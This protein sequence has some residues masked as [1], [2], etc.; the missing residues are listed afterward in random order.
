M[1]TLL[2]CRRGARKNTRFPRANRDWTV[3]ARRRPRPSGLLVALSP[4]VPEV[5][6]GSNNDLEAERHAE[7]H[8][9]FA[10]SL[11]RQGKCCPFISLTLRCRTPKRSAKTGKEGKRRRVRRN[12]EAKGREKRALS[13]GNVRPERIR[14][15]MF[16]DEVSMIENLASS[17]EHP[18]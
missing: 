13:T 1:F 2:R 18:T 5:K 17:V 10:R 9:V 4:A 16:R 11:S 8:F 6:R 12:S 3:S 15:Q 14:L 7:L